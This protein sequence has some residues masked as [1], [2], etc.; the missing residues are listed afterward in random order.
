MIH[1]LH[2]NMRKL[3]TDIISKFLS[4]RYLSSF[5]SSDG[6]LKINDLD[7]LDLS[8]K[9]NYKAKLD[10]GCKALELLQKNDAL[11][12]KR[13][14]EGTLTKVYINAARYLIDNLPLTSQIIHARGVLHP[15][16]ISKP[17]TASSFQRL[18]EEV[19]KC[20]G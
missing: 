20:L 5:M 3:V 18:V 14:M 6:L 9:K 1:I 13:F 2:V 10:I 8:N 4:T 15:N 19:W 7:D 17:G 12:K 11:E 16:W